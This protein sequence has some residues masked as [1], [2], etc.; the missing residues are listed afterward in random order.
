MR[1][2]K[3]K[4]DKE[5]YENI[6]TLNKFSWGCLFIGLQLLFQLN[7]AYM[8]TSNHNTNKS[9]VDCLFSFIAFVHTVKL[10]FLDCH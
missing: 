2:D 5:G 3:E 10:V 4:S 9:W 1:D 8:H 6:G 7:F